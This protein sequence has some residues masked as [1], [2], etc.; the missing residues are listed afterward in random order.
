[1]THAADP[2][3]APEMLLMRERMR[4]WQFCD[5][6]RADAD[7]SACRPCV[8]AR[9]M[10]LSENG[11]DLA[12][13][14]ATLH[15]N[16]DG[17]AFDAALADAFEGGATAI[18]GDELI[19]VAM[20]QRGMLRAPEPSDGTLRYLLLVAASLSPGPAPLTALNG[21]GTSLHPYLLQPLARLITVAAARTQAIV[22]THAAPLAAA[23]R[24]AGATFHALHKELSETRTEADP[25]PWAWPKRTL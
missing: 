24:D 2:D 7:A 16:G 25:P 4:R 10:S 13:A 5:H 8:G 6:F 12:P 23:S 11:H 9:A 3:H 15:E 14:I 1:M 17:P 18:V 21:P 19:E 20:I 22:V